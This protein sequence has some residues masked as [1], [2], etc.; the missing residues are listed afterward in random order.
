MHCLQGILT[1][2]EKLTTGG[3]LFGDQTQLADGT[4]AATGFQ[5][6]SGLDSNDDGKINA[7]DAVFDELKV[8]QDKNQ[9]GISQADELKAKKIEIESAVYKIKKTLNNISLAKKR[10]RKENLMN[11]IE[12]NS[13]IR[14]DETQ[15]RKEWR[16]LSLRKL[17][18][19]VNGT[20]KQIEITI[21][22]EVVTSAQGIMCIVHDNMPKSQ[23]FPFSTKI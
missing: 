3:E 8:W 21:V 6:L 9:D 13:K 2:M 10:R 14:S 12:N 11:L 18:S 4:T 22:G 7:D 20:V 16:R 17:H 5:A 19:P 23:K 1:V 15:L